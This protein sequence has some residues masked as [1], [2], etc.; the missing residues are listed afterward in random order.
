MDCVYFAD[1]PLNVPKLDLVF[2]LS[3]TSPDKDE[4]FQLMTDTVKSLLQRYDS[5]NIRF[6]LL[7]YSEDVNIVVDLKNE[8]DA[9]GMKAELAVIAPSVGLSALDRALEAAKNMFFEAGDRKDADRVLV[10]MTDKNSLVDEEEI[11]GATKPLEK[12]AV[13]IIPV[14]IGDEVDPT[15]F[16]F[17]A[18]KENIIETNKDEDSTDL[19]EE[20]MERVISE[21]ILCWK[22][23]ISEFQKPLFSLST[24]RQMQNPLHRNEF[25]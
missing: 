25:I 24:E 15:N 11:I 7:E 3:S 9:A 19:G 16:K 6:G 2:A 14:V 23:V 4:T 20:I 12:M 10:V 22:Q 8:T 5:S 1:R 21:S 18:P 13:K 17:V